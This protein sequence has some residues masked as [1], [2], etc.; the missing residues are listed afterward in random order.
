MVVV[1]DQSGRHSEGA[2]AS[3]GLDVLATASFFA[4]LESAGES[5]LSSSPRAIATEIDDSN[6]AN[7]MAQ[8]A[9]VLYCPR[10]RTLMGLLA[11]VLD[12]MVL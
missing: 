12:G 6:A 10:R 11:R 2:P 4:G 9:A 8:P 5:A 7:S 3:A 1:A